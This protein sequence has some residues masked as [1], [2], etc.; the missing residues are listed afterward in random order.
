MTTSAL[1]SS[2]VGPN[3]G[4]PIPPL[5]WAADRPAASERVVGCFLENL[6]GRQK[7]APLYSRWAEEVL[8]T[9]PDAFQ[10]F[11]T[12]ADKK[13]TVATGALPTP[14]S[15][16]GPVLVVYNH[17]FGLWDG[18]VSASVTEAMGR[19]FKFVAHEHYAV[20]MPHLSDFIL[21]ISWEGSKEASRR[22]LRTRKRA[23]EELRMGHTVGIFPAGFVATA[24]RGFGHAVEQ[25][26]QPL[27]A[28]LVLDTPCT[29]LPVFCEGQMGR[30]AQIARAIHPALG[31]LNQLTDFY[32]K[33]GEDVR[34]HI[35]NPIP[36]EALEERS[37]RQRLTH[38][39]RERTLDLGRAAGAYPYPREAAQPHA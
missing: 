13:L 6:F 26:W 38:E 32:D 10:Q 27:A 3:T 18:F 19:P 9:A 29:V 33:F 5:S 15:I 34:I 36:F 24:P 25:P 17:P 21:P 39:L 31:E 4:R 16:P 22:N 20:G 12:M 8:P 7:H 2:F 1:T 23:T 28:R 35:G 11:L 37:S 14:E 30:V